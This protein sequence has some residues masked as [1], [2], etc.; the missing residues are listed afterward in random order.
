[1]VLD[2]LWKRVLLQ[3]VV[4]PLLQVAETQT[5]VQELLDKETTLFVRVIHQGKLVSLQLMNEH[6]NSI[7]N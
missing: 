6:N 4:V 7:L 1:M 3:S 5:S 2:H